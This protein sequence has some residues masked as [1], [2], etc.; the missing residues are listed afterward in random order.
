MATAIE[1]RIQ[2]YLINASTKS[3]I[4]GGDN[5]LYPQAVVVTGIN[6]I[7]MILL[8]NPN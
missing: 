6:W 3:F 1:I 4:A 7:A 5:K 8:K 2:G